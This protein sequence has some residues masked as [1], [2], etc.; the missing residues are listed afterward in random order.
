[1]RATRSYGRPGTA[2]LPAGWGASHAPVLEQTRTATISLATGGT[3]TGEWNPE[4]ESYD[5]PGAATAYASSVP[6][7]IMPDRST[8]DPRVE[9]AGETLEVFDYLVGIAHDQNT[10]REG[11]IATV[12]ACEGD[13]ELVGRQLRVERADFG[14]DRFERVLHCSLVEDR[15]EAAS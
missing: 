13:P 14:S 6:A 10:V 15:T 7:S 8:G 2:V 9:A 11:H 1:M 12:T 5:A 4:T 3:T